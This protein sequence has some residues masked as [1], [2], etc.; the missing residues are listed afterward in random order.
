VL[1]THYN[2]HCKMDMNEDFEAQ[3]EAILFEKVK[4][5]FGID[6]IAKS[7]KQFKHDLMKMLDET[8]PTLQD[9]VSWLSHAKIKRLK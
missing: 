3:F 4:D 2:K 7:S 9:I 6:D 1:L 5:K 8:K